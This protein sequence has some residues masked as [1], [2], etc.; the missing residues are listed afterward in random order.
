MLARSIH[1]FIQLQWTS[2]LEPISDRVQP[3]G[4]VRRAS[5][6]QRPQRIPGRGADRANMHAH[7]AVRVKGLWGGRL[8]F[9]IWQEKLIF[10]P[11][12]LRCVQDS[13][14]HR[15]TQKLPDIYIP[16]GKET[17]AWRWQ[18]HL[19][20][21]DEVCGCDGGEYVEGSFLGSLR[22]IFGGYQ[23]FDAA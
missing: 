15:P 20:R 5:Q 13:C 3:A 8:Q 23:R 2:G 14:A 19:F 9:K 16:G 1:L 22:A 11:L 18:C 6:A 4:D 12:R 21:S 7:K 10:V 17:G